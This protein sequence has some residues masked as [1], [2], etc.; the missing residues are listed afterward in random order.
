MRSCPCFPPLFPH[1][2]LVS[3]AARLNTYGCRLRACQGPNRNGASLVRDTPGVSQVGE[4]NGTENRCGENLEW[5]PW[6]NAS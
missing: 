6:V 4:P 1:V 2:P 5:E 3:A